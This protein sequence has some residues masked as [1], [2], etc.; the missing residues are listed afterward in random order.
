MVLIPTEEE[1]GLNATCLAAAKMFKSGT[2]NNVLV[3]S[4]FVSCSKKAAYGAKRAMSES[5][6]YDQSKLLQLE[7]GTRFASSKVKRGQ[8]GEGLRQE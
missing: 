5:S 2:Y 6:K 1:P 8:L 7:S 3:P 4:H